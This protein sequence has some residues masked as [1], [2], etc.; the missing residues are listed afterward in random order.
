MA[1]A[2]P[3]LLLNERPGFNAASHLNL[4]CCRFAA[5]V[6]EVAP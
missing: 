1:G 3:L 2:R 6:K 5:L 4:V